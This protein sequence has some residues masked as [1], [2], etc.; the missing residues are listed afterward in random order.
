MGRENPLVNQS[1]I[2]SLLA[3]ELGKKI[4]YQSVIYKTSQY[5]L[6]Y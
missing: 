1:L 5:V 3:A 2:F 4:K 6:G